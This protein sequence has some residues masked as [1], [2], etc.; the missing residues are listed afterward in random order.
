MI[1]TASLWVVVMTYTLTNGTTF[2]VES[3]PRHYQSCQT[4][5]AHWLS[6]AAY[7]PHVSIVRGSCEERKRG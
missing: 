3:E 5:K 1:A 7:N 4:L 2:T 6:R